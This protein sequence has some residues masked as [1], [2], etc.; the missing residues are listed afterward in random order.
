MIPQEKKDHG[1]VLCGFSHHFLRGFAIER[2]PPISPLMVLK[3]M[4]PVQEIGGSNVGAN[5][6]L[7]NSN[8]QRIKRE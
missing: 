3:S 7:K 2:V 6:A 4:G 1:C 5:L 8:L